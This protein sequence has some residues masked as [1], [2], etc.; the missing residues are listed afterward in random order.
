MFFNNLNFIGFYKLLILKDTWHFKI[1]EFN[2]Q[3]LLVFLIQL[4]MLI[5]IFKNIAKCHVL[6]KINNLY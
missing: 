2:S 1:V 4:F 3:V 6:L 5:F